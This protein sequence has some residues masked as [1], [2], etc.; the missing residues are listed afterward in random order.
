[1]ENAALCWGNKLKILPS[2]LDP[3]DDEDEEEEGGKWVVDCDVFDPPPCTVEAERERA[4]GCCGLA[5][6]T[7]LARL[8][9]MFAMDLTPLTRADLDRSG[10]PIPPKAPVGLITKG[11]SVVT[12]KV[13]GASTIG[14]VMVTGRQHASDNAAKA[15]APFNILLLFNNVGACVFKMMPHS[16]AT[17][18]G[19]FGTSKTFLSIRKEGW[20]N[21]P[22]MGGVER[23]G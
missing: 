17:I 18:V 20:K 10:S 8:L 11:P 15:A 16:A 6:E 2:V 13:R 21:S 1:M 7:R 4:G 23:V 19:F 12:L 3:P 22:T 9:A 5:I 14:L